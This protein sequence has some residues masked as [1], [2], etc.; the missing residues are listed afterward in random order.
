MT[1][2]LAKIRGRLVTMYQAIPFD[3]CEDIAWLVCEIDS[4]TKERDAWRE[5]WGKQS[6]E[7]V[8]L[9]GGPKT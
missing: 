5:A 4:L 2:R 8:R 3:T 1:D 6:A 7:C 9:A